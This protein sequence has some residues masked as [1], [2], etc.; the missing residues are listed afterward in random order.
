MNIQNNCLFLIKYS[1]ISIMINF[2]D[3]YNIRESA[4][5]KANE[6]ALTPLELFALYTMINATDSSNEMKNTKHKLETTLKSHITYI[7]RE[8]KDLGNYFNY[9]SYKSVN[10][11][12]IFKDMS[13]EKAD[14]LLDIIISEIHYRNKTKKEHKRYI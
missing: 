1:Y 3:I 11:N 7:L 5:D 14:E 12:E 6:I 9:D 8:C 4:L 13:K 10:Y 2:S